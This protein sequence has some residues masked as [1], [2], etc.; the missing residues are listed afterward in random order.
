M[1]GVCLGLAGVIWAQLPVGAFSLAW[2]HSV[3]KVRWEEDYQV[4]G[5]ELYLAEARVQGSGAGMEM[6]A[7]ARLDRGFWHYRPQLILPLL[8]LGRTPEAGD[9]QLCQAAGCRPMSD[10][11]GAPD[12]ALP[13]VEVWGCDVG[14]DERL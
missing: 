3:E 11:L 7:G 4:R 14:L 13:V 8:R 12:A 9:Y 10:W 6:P 1:I 2:E 5:R